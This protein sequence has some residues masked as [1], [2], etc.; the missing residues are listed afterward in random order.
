MSKITEDEIQDV[1]YEHAF[2]TS[3]K[4]QN[5][6]MLTVGSLDETLEQMVVAAAK[7]IYS[8]TDDSP[9]AQARREKIG[10]FKTLIQKFENKHGVSPSWLR[11][12]H[13]ENTFEGQKLFDHGGYIEGTKVVLLISKSKAYIQEAGISAT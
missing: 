4:I 12:G 11:F 1:L 5:I 6:P 13:D 2:Q 8:L 3:R 9:I 10:E 7:E